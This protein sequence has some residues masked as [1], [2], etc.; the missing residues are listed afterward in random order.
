MENNTIK[1]KCDVCGKEIVVDRF[2]NG[3]GCDRCGWKQSEESFEHPNTAGIRNIPALN[4]AIKQ[5]K[6]GQSAILGNFNDFVAAFKNYGELE[7]TYNDT[8]YGVLFDDENNK[9]A[10]LNIKTNQKQYYIDVNDFTNN[11]QIDGINLKLLWDSVT[12]TDFLQDTN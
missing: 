4:N 8:R 1:T 7:F 5:Y 11:A 3:D 6:A 2:G 12:S 10:L 9:I